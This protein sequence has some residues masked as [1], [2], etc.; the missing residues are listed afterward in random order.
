M[1]HSRC[2]VIDAHLRSYTVT[3]AHEHHLGCNFCEIILETPLLEQTMD[4][5]NEDDFCLEQ[6]AI[7]RVT[8]FSFQQRMGILWSIV[9]ELRYQDKRVSLLH[10]VEVKVID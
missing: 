6:E 10:I 7:I 2:G 4:E 5:N 3:F 8:V 9:D 1:K